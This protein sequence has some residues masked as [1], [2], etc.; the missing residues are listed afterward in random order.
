MPALSNTLGDF[1]SNNS[2]SSS[3][4]LLAT[5]SLKGTLTSLAQ[6]QSEPSLSYL[7]KEATRRLLRF[8]FPFV[9][10][11]V[12]MIKVYQKWMNV[13]ETENNLHLIQSQ[14]ILDQFDDLEGRLREIKFAFHMANEEGKD[15]K[16]NLSGWLNY[17]YWTGHNI[18]FF[19]SLIKVL[20]V[21]RK[22]T[23]TS[24]LHNSI[25]VSRTC[26]I[27]SKLPKSRLY[28]CFL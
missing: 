2:A 8:W 21:S 26:N 24:I 18:K 7:I 25:F 9:C 22:T 14:Q 11:Q 4:L 1:V 27:K 5:E 3:I 15:N 28:G 23:H 20:A 13:L 16:S 12:K 19:A 6:K 17:G 10:L